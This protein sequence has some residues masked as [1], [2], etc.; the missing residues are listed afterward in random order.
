ML[1][2]VPVWAARSHRQLRGPGGRPSRAGGALRRRRPVSRRRRRQGHRALL[3]HRQ[4]GR[5][6]LRVLARRRVRL[7]RFA[8][9]RP[10]G[11]GHHRPRD[12]G[13]GQAPLPRDRRRRRRRG[14]HRRRGRRHVRRRVRQRDAALAPHPAGGRLQPRP[15]LRRPRPRRGHRLRRAA[16]AVRAAALQLGRLR[17]LADLRGRRRVAAHGQVDPPDRADA[18]GARRRRVGPVARRAHLGDPAR[19]GRPLLQR[20]RRHLRQGD[21]RDQRR[22]RRPRQR[23][24]AHR[25]PRAAL[26]GRRRGRQPRPHPARADRVRVA[27]RQRFGRRP[28]LH[29][30]GR[31]RRRGQLLRPRGQH[32]DPARQPDRVRRAGQRGPRPG[33]GLDDRRGRRG[34]AVRQLYPDP[35]AVAVPAAGER[36]ARRPRPPDPLAGDPTPAWTARSRCCRPRRCSPSAAPRAAVS[37]PRSCAC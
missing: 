28:D 35:G 36:D 7:R 22:G 27:G 9:L 26:P 18:R 17:P 34:G 32:Q 13:V 23:R 8:R 31:Q 1:P 5:R 21:R 10:Q 37:S 15:H 6:R 24:T 16:A 33:A 19:A 2:D 14:L 4:R 11:D 12:L 30:R 3:G 29:R 25:R 20:R